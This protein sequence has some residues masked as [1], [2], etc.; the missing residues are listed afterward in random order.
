MK[1][2]AIIANTCFESSIILAKHLSDQNY[3]VDYY[4]ITSFE[5]RSVEGINFCNAKNKLG[6]YT[7][8]GNDA[9]ELFSYLKNAH[10]RVHL[11][12][13]VRNSIKFKLL[14]KI[15]LLIVSRKI[16]KCKYNI[17]NYIGHDEL[18]LFLYKKLIKFKSIFTIHEVAAHWEGQYVNLNVLLFLFRNNIPIITP[19]N[20]SYQRILQN[21]D[22][23]KE[24]IYM[25]PF[26]LIDKTNYVLFFGSFR[27]YKGLDVLNKALGLLKNHGIKFVIAGYGY[28]PDIEMLRLNDNCMIINRFLTNE[29][30]VELI[31]KA[32]IIVCPY[33]SVS[34]SGIIMTTFIFEKPVIASDIGSFKEIIENGN[35]GLLI[36]PESPEELAAAIQNIYSN[37]VLYEK[38]VEGVK[39]K[40]NLKKYEWESIA[41]LT[42]SVYSRYTNI[43]EI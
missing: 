18:I 38:L 36:K 25:I 8:K 6:L 27:P 21:R 34:Q 26:E 29:E 22:C 9:Y 39:Q 43:M 4:L 35:N 42:I 41:K 40:K 37:K 12:K 5:K 28:N 16:N 23:K 3:F 7:L 20:L 15:V 17:I 33:K 30:I 1:K 31:K 2:I 11:I 19:S 10:V 13:I 24:N 14:N 32:K